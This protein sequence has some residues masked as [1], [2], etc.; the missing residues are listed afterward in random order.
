MMQLRQSD[1]GE[2][3]VLQPWVVFFLAAFN[4]SSNAVSYCTVLPLKSEASSSVL[5]CTCMR[6][7]RIQKN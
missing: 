3:G 2:M 4:G 6:R 5:S 7:L 1:R